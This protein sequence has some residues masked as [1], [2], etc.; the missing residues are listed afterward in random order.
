MNEGIKVE[1]ARLLATLK[2][3]REAHREEFL[4]AQEKFRERVIE[5]LDQ[6]LAEAKKGSKVDLY[7]RLPEPEDYTY[8]Y[9]AAIAALDWMIG[10]EVTLD[11]HE[12]KQLVLNQWEWAAAFAGNTQAYTSGKWS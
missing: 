11:D 1:K 4:A 3:N 2:E 5:A 7:I 8:K 6:R 12:F 9:D 10:D